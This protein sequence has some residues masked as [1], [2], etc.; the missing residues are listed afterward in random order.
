MKGVSEGGSEGG[1]AEGG[2][3]GFHLDSTCTVEVSLFNR[4]VF[5][6]RDPIGGLDLENILKYFIYFFSDELTGWTI[7][8]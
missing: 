2:S 5:V 7:P 1:S 3:K 4:N 8:Q 6:K